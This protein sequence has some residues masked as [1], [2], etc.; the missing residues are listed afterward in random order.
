MSIKFDDFMAAMSKLLP[1]IGETVV[2]LHPNNANEAMKIGLGINLIQ[3]AATILHQ[4]AT[5]A[6]ATNVSPTAPNP[7]PAAGSVPA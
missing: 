2:A 1:A 3:A 5:D 6:T 4:S 7:A